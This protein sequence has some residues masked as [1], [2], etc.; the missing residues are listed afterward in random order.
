MSLQSRSSLPWLIAWIALSLLA[1]G[2]LAWWDS[3]R[4]RAD[5]ES[6]LLTVHRLLSLRAVE[7]EAIL[8]TLALLDSP[9]A[10]DAAQ[11]V[12]SIYPRILQ[13]LRREGEE[14]W[15][16]G[17]RARALAAAEVAS[18]REGRAWGLV[19]ELDRGRLGLVL[20][21]P[22]VSY[23][24]VVDLSMLA[25]A[26]DWPF[27]PDAP[28]QVRL[29]HAGHDWTVHSAAREGGL[30]LFSFEKR[31]AAVGQ[32]FDVV[33][34]RWYGWG[35]LPWGQM[36]LAV[37]MTGVVLGGA[38][39]L[40]QQRRARRRAEELLRL[41][42]VGRL[43]ALGE[44]AAGMAHELNQPL[45]AILANTRAADRMLHDDPPELETARQAMRAASDQ[46]RRAADVLARMRRA[47]ERPD[48]G[49]ESRP[50]DLRAV[51]EAVLHLL[52][53]EL[54]RLRVRLDVDGPGELKVQA[55]PVS[56]EQ[57][58]HNLL[59]N[60]MQA[61]GQ[62]PEH[63]RRLS[64]RLL[65][66][67]AHGQLVVADTGPGIPPAERPRVFEPFFTTRKGGLGLGLSLCE[68]L[69]QASGGRIEFV[70]P[71]AR[72]ATFVL[73]LALAHRDDKQQ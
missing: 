36:L 33:G 20:A 71:P 48:A 38:A 58:V 52:E 34:E 55:D 23:A 72:G 29:A 18:L 25:E 24:L 40:S 13:V 56:V 4:Q 54:R 8:S 14:Q 15:A 47:V 45:T 61:L 50:V 26:A 31:L 10:A 27:E 7:H 41:G 3:N 69:A 22:R 37:V 63:E 43:N 64:L 1:V 66:D 42:Q 39:I 9:G 11:R 70:A 57:I 17:A 6:K 30:V 67:A 46:A 12:P 59:M 60:A 53:P 21:G 73:T 19:S 5:F 68:S 28:V 49:S 16:D 51:L 62:V 32:P 2:A 65:A 44:L 35:D